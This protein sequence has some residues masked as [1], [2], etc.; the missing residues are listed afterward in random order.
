[1]P[2]ARSDD[3]VVDRRGEAGQRHGG[4]L[5][6]VVG[7]IRLRQQVRLHARRRARREHARGAL[8]HARGV[9]GRA[10]D[11]AESRV[12]ADRFGEPDPS[13]GG[14]LAAELRGHESLGVAEET[15]PRL[16]ASLEVGAERR[17]GQAPAGDRG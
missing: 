7:A 11:E 3:H 13:V 12:A 2:V 1:M 8:E 6:L 10:L 16:A 17:A 15:L 9:H 5:E 14:V 4:V